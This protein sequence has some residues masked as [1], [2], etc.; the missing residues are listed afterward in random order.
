MQCR[1]GPIPEL[2]WIARMTNNLQYFES[3]SGKTRCLAV[4]IDYSICNTYIYIYVNQ[5]SIHVI[6][7]I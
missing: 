5:K 4:F 3:A 7:D 1:K 2:F 6:I